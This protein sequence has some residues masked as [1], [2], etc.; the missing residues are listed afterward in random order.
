MYT[1]DRYRE[2][3]EQFRSSARDFDGD[4]PNDEMARTLLI[5][6]QEL[7]R[8]HR[9]VDQEYG[10]E[11]SE[12][13]QYQ[14]VFF[15]RGLHS[16]YS[17]HWLVKRYR[18]DA[19]HR[20]V[21]FLLETYFCVRGLNRDKDEAAAIYNAYR[22]EVEE[23]GLDADAREVALHE[24]D[25]VDDLFDVWRDERGRAKE[26]WPEVR[27]YYNYVSNRSTHPVRLY[28]AWDDGSWSEGLE[29]ELLTWGLYL[30]YGLCK[31]L[32][33]TYNDTSAGPFIK[34]ESQQ[35]VAR[36]DEVLGK[37]VPTFLLESY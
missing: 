16:L 3:E 29:E 19:A 9:A 34:R 7:A 17:L 15:T 23:L 14:D 2:I 8:I 1:E 27:Q 21:R 10:N 36:F 25:A 12:R 30:S 18:Y 4:H 31:E 28:G 24:F 5:T 6:T 32:L 13:H 37:D 33:K 22:E 35:V 26:V 20:E 11:A